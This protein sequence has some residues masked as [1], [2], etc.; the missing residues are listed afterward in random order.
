MDFI[1]FSMLRIFT[2]N[3]DWCSCMGILMRIQHSSIQTC[4]TY[5]FKYKFHLHTLY[6]FVVKILLIPIRIENNS[7]P[8]WIE[9]AHESYLKRTKEKKIKT[10]SFSIASIKTSLMNTRHCLKAYKNKSHTEAIKYPLATLKSAEANDF[11]VC[12]RKCDY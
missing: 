9:S 12:W 11:F 5:D 6:H 7:S 3:L 10:K 8:P 4:R 2:E 1:N